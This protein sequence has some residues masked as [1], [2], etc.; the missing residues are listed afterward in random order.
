MDMSWKLWVLLALGGGVLGNAAW[1]MLCG[2]A[3]LVDRRVPNLAMW[4]ART[5]T[6]LLPEQLRDDPLYN[7]ENDAHAALEGGYRYSALRTSLGA[8]AVA[9]PKAKLRSLNQRQL[10]YGLTVGL[11][12]G[13]TAGLAA[14]LTYGLAAGLAA[15]LAYGLTDRLTDRLADRLAS[16]QGS[17]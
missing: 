10:T 3:R 2:S 15:G 13:L 16:G 1:A 11:T 12:V 9:V 4:L 14:G 5:A 7:F 8:C 17:A 6:R